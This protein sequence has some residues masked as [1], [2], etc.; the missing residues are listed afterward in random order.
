MP[1]KEERRENIK[2]QPHKSCC[3]DLYHLAK[4]PA[5]ITDEDI[6]FYDH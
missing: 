5:S 3:Q 1:S 4:Q 2:L 6:L